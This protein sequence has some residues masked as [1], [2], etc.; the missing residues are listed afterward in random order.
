MP[1]SEPDW[2]RRD[3]SATMNGSVSRRLLHHHLVATADD[4]CSLPGNRCRPMGRPRRSGRL[5][6]TQVRGGSA[7]VAQVGLD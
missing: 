2:S 4:A 5:R 7:P 3:N 1:G 6:Q